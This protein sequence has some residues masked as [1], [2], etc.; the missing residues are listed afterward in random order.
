MRYIYSN[1]YS[2]NKKTL[3]KTVYSLNQGNIAGLPTETVYG[4]AGNAYSDKAVKKIFR[5]KKRPKKNPLI[6]HYDNYKNASN[7][8]LFNKNF[9]KLYKKFCPGPMT[10]VLKKN[11]KSKISSLA[12][13][14][15]DT[16]AIRFPRHPVIKTVLKFLNF[17]LAMPSANL[18]SGLSPVNAL[19]VFDEFKRKLKIIING[20]NSIVGI[21]STVIDLTGKPKILRPGIITSSDL[22]K[23]LKLNIK[24]R[25]L[26]IKAPGMMEKHYSPGIPVVIGKKPKS[27]DDAYIVFG[28]KFKN[29]ENYFNLSKKGDLKEAAANLYKIMRKI[30]K[31]GYKK[32]FVSN[33]P[34]FGPGI[35]INDRLLR[36]SR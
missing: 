18:S 10:F 14:K 5:L 6:I 29:F 11:K 32:I 36:A 3:K 13:A 17:P 24:K 8:V 27:L 7:D 26:K 15:L 23:I 30:K 1:I 2:F 34:K 12:T 28:K 33:I 4:L 9:F 20:G 21:E 31:N 35:A 22:R 19:D 25:K 16:V